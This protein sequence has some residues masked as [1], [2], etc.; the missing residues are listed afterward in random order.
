LP[1][2]TDFASTRE[3]TT[4]AAFKGRRKRSK[5]LKKK[6]KEFEFNR[7]DRAGMVGNCRSHEIHGKKFKK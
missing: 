4:I 2:D 1:R 6:L 3:R 7:L 5:D